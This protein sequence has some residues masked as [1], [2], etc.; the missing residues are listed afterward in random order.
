MT[1]KIEHSKICIYKIGGILGITNK[2][3][4]EKNRNIYRE[5]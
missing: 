2:N 5:T 1:L 3:L 4:T